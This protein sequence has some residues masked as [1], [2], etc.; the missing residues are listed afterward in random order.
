[1]KLKI[2]QV[3]QKFQIQERIPCTNVF[4]KANISGVINSFSNIPAALRIIKKKYGYKGEE[5]KI[6][7]DYGVNKDRIFAGETNKTIPRQKR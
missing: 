6:I 3:C 7:I 2:I 1:M 4:L 5:L